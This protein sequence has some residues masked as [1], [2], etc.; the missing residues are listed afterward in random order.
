MDADILKCCIV[1]NVLAVDIS[2]EPDGTL[3][4]TDA[5]GNRFRIVVE[6]IPAHKP[7]ANN[8]EAK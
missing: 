7:E 3:L 2:F 4:A 5:D 6:Q 1:A 8:E